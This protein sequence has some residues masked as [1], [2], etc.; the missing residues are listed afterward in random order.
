MSARLGRA[1]QEIKGR[2][3]ACHEGIAIQHGERII[4][5]ALMN[6]SG[7]RVG[8]EGHRISQNRA[9][10]I[11]TTQSDWVISTAAL[12]SVTTFRH[13]L[14]AQMVVVEEERPNLSRCSTTDTTY[15]GGFGFETYTPRQAPSRSGPPKPV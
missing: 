6:K 1:S 10:R 7:F 12:S 3:P 11:E 8:R 9:T 13:P 14:L 2:D 4:A 5:C 15:S